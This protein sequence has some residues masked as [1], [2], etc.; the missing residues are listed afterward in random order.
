MNKKNSLP[1]QFDYIVFNRNIWQSSSCSKLLKSFKIVDN[2]FYF[3]PLT[4]FKVF[5]IWTSWG[6][7]K[8]HEKCICFKVHLDFY[9][10]REIFI[11]FCYQEKTLSVDVNSWFLLIHDQGISFTIGPLLSSHGHWSLYDIFPDILRNAPHE[12]FR[13]LIIYYNQ[14]GCIKI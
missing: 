11:L 3:C 7:S 8:F 13:N 14:Q 2:S 10:L 12:K 5:Y 1:Y 9:V 4:F 6:L